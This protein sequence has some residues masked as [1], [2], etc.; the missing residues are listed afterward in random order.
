M[1]IIIV[2]YNKPKKDKAG[3]CNYIGLSC[4]SYYSM[5]FALTNFINWTIFLHIS[6]T[7]NTSYNSLQV[8][9][10]PWGDD[11]NLLDYTKSSMSITTKR[12]MLCGPDRGVWYLGERVN[13]QSLRRSTFVVPKNPPTLML[14]TD[15]FNPI[16]Y[17]WAT[18]G[19]P[20]M[21]F[22]HIESESQYQ[23]FTAKFRLPNKVI[24]LK[25]HSLHIYNLSI[26]YNSRFIYIVLISY[27]AL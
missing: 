8:N 26:Y 15:K 24:I 16:P 5:R 9:W 12:I 13:V 10:S 27:T 14:L 2:H 7:L 11:D 1:V 4:L 23:T 25:V 17:H 6:Y 22:L 19:K 20:A 21:E 3:C 18:K